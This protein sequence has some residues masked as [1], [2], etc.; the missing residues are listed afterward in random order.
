MACV[1]IVVFSW[2]WL[3]WTHEAGHVIAG[4]LTGA[5]LERV[6]LDPRTFSRTDFG[7]NPHPHIV[8]WGG[9][10]L[11]CVIG[12]GLPLLVSCRAV[13]WRAGLL[14]VA[15]LVLIGNGLYIGLG[16]FFPVGDA[17]VMRDLGS[18]A[19]VLCVF[20]LAACL[21]GRYILRKALA[22]KVGGHHGAPR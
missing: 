6:V 8:V 22:P 7:A 3:Q 2:L 15:G 16:A 1:S 21:P 18:P 5:E 19:W 4:L 17:E 14:G 13:R 12:A 10:V 20:G 11:G 9:P